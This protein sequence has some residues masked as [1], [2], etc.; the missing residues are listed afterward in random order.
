[1]KKQ[2]KDVKKGDKI[3]LAGE[4]ML[5]EETETSDTS[6]Q[7]TKKCRI[8]VSNKK[9]NKLTIIRPADYILEVK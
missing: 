3:I 2:A 9:G 6:K 8:V 7:G 4:E 5:V 1:M